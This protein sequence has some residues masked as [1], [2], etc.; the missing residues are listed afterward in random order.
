MKNIIIYTSP[1][2][3]DKLLDKHGIELD[4]LKDAVKYGKPKITKQEGK[5]YMA[6]T[7]H[8]RYI[9]VI[10]EYNK[11]FAN[12]ITAY[13]SSESHIRRYKKK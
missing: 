11:P 8:L 1:S 10:F 6:I 7:H 3:Q 5:I 12:I 2:V 9:T 13:P 4:E